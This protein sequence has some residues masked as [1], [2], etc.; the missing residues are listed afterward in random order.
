MIVKKF[1]KIGHIET[2]R[3]VCWS[4]VVSYH[5]YHACWPREHINKHKSTDS[6][7]Y[8]PK[9]TLMI[10]WQKR[11]NDMKWCEMGL[12]NCVWTI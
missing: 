2:N 10:D 12:L 7:N 5:D 6:S 9:Y 3:K 4:W 1:H 11:I 8:K